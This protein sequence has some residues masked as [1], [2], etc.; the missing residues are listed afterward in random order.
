MAIEQTRSNMHLLRAPRRI[1][2]AELDSPR[3]PIGSGM[4]LP[5]LVKERHQMYQERLDALHKKLDLTQPV[6]ITN[7]TVRNPEPYRTGDGDVGFCVRPGS[8]HAFT[9]PSRGNRT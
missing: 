3:A 8:M 9:L 1:T 4:A 6:R 2:K 5:G 7:A